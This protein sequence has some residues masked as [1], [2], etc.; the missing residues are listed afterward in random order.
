MPAL[1]RRR[2]PDASQETWLIHYDDF[3]P[4]FTASNRGPPCAR[5]ALPLVQERSARLWA[6]GR[7]SVSRTRPGNVH[8]ASR[9]K[10]LRCG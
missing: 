10:M 1:T 3:G 9:L 6:G 8:A 4:N 2:D 5:W 7:T